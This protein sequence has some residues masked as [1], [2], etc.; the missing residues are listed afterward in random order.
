MLSPLGIRGVVGAE[1]AADE[2]LDAVIGAYR[3]RPAVARALVEW[4]WR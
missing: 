1:V 2:L 4:T 3:L